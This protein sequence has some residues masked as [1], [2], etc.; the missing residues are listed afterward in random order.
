DLTVTAAADTYEALVGAAVTVPIQANNIG[1]VSAETDVNP[2]VD[3]WD[4]SLWTSADGAFDP[5]VDT[6][7]GSYTVTTLASGGT[8]T[9]N[10]VFNAPAIGTYTL[11]GWADSDEEVTESSEV[12]NSALLGTLSVGPDLTI[13]ID[14]AFVTGDE[15]IPGDRWRI[16]VQVTNG[17]VGTASGLATIQLYG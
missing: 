2:G 15:Q 11:F 7:V 8:V 17:G 13:A 14:D 12:N 9:D 1:D 4:V 6:E 5:L 3:T 10:V 16:P